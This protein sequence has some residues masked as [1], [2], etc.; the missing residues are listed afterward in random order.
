MNIGTALVPVIVPAGPLTVT[1]PATGTLKVTVTDGYLYGDVYQVFIN[2]TSAGDT[3]D[4]TLGP[5]DGTGGGTYSTGEF[6]VAVTVGDTVSIDI[7]DILYQYLSSDGSVA[8]PY[9]GGSALLSDRNN[10]GLF[11]VAQETYN[12]VTTPEPASAALLGVGLLGLGFGIGWRRRSQ[13]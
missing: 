5:P 2:G 7:A 8:D 10:A 3:S 12:V 6:D 9:G 11:V 4:V 1:A 13:T